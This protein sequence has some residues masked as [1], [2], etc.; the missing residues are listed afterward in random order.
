MPFAKC[1]NFRL[2][3][4][5]TVIAIYMWAHTVPR[6]RHMQSTSNRFR[7]ITR[8]TVDSGGAA[9]VEKLFDSTHTRNNNDSSRPNLQLLLVTSASKLKE[10]YGAH[11]VNL[12]IFF[13]P[14][15][16]SSH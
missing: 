10:P 15:S 8:R 7:Y 12:A 9:F 11:R 5:S 2:G 3:I 6:E 14:F 13:R 1:A 4:V 16:K